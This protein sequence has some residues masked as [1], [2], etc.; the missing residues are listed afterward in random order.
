MPSEVR[1]QVDRGQ[2]YPLVRLI[3]V[4]DGETSAPI[5]SAL[6]DVLATQP[7]AVVVDVTG[8]RV[9]DVDSVA[10]LRE[11]L[12]ETRDW[13]GSHL[14]LSG[15]LDSAAWQPSGWPLWPDTAGA[16]AA[17]G[18]PEPRHR[19]SLDLEPVVGA[20]RRSRELITEACGRWEQPDLAGNACIVVTE[21]VN[22]V[23]AHAG[24][25]MS[26]LVALHGDTMSVAVRDSSTTLPRFTG[27]VAPTSYGGRG[28]LLIDSVSSRWGRLP[29]EGGKVVWALLEAEPPETLR[30][31]DDAGMTDP[32]RG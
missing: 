2:T 19:I 27:P 14:A 6:L 18:T 24:T 17:L 28:L 20:A 8:L 1:H 15:S 23:V 4:L 9:T 26:V 16:F 22:N 12:D 13:P 31:R 21:M 11:V 30:P 32:A 7:E 3:G 10:V 29:L 5:R 25:P